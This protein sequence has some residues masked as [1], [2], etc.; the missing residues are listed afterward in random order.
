[1]DEYRKLCYL[2]EIEV[3]QISNWIAGNNYTLN[4]GYFRLSFGFS[5]YGNDVFLSYFQGDNRCNLEVNDDVTANDPLRTVDH[6]VID[7]HCVQLK[8]SSET[9]ESYFKYS[10]DVTEAHVNEDCEPPGSSLSFE[11]HHDHCE[12]IA[13]GSKTIETR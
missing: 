1:M 2:T 13:G 4:Q 5:P 12:L 11:L 6:I 10:R 7:N 3:E 9:L 8:I